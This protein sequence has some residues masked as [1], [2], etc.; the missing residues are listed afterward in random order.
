M[1]PIKNRQ[2]GVLVQQFFPAVVLGDLEGLVRVAL[3]IVQIKGVGGGIAGREAVLGSEIE[4][5]RR[6]V[7]GI[8]AA[9]G[10]SL[11]HAALG[12]AVA[13]RPDS[14]FAIGAGDFFGGL[15]NFQI[16]LRVALPAARGD[17]GFLESSAAEKA[18][19]RPHGWLGY[20]RLG[21]FS[22]RLVVAGASA[23]ERSRQQNRYR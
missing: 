4:A 15:R 19:C 22:R 16:G 7:S 3:E 10:E 18:F 6:S 9:P 5:A 13:G 12:G 14:G 11:G 1:Q 20:G 21:G 2:L 17:K 8:G 23:Q